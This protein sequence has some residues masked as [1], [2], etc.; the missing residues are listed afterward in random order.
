M[1]PHNIAFHGTVSLSLPAVVAAQIH[2]HRQ[3]LGFMQATEL[4]LCALALAWPED[5]AP[6]VAVERQRVTHARRRIA[7]LE[8]Q[9]REA[10]PQHRPIIATDLNAARREMMAA[11]TEYR[12]AQVADIPADPGL[13]SAIAKRVEAALVAAKVPPLK[14]AMWAAEIFNACAAVASEGWDEWAALEEAGFST[15]TG[16]GSSSTGSPSP[17]GG[18]GTRGTGGA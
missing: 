7:G 14:I 8:Q 5:S 13:R 1:F 17:L 2:A 16:D 9:L 3:G 12:A 4:A 18:P 6:W 15:A 11:E 10:E